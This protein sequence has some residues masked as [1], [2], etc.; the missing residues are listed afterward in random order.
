MKISEIFAKKAKKLL[1]NLQFFRVATEELQV[2]L[3]GYTSNL[4]HQRCDNKKEKHK[5]YR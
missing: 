1:N 2:N 4:F 5:G 3:T